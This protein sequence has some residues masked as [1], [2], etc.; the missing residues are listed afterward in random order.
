MKPQRDP[1]HVP[2]KRRFG[3]LNQVFEGDIERSFG[4][5]FKEFWDYW[6]QA[7]DHKVA[8]E[9]HIFRRGLVTAI[10]GAS[11]PLLVVVSGFLGRDVQSVWGGLLA[12]VSP[13][14]AVFLG[15]W[16]RRTLASVNRDEAYMEKRGPVLEGILKLYDRQPPGQIPSPREKREVDGKWDAAT[17]ELGPRGA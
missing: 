5:Y 17:L 6:S 2:F 8:R 12:A 1:P 9:R 7:P 15:S 11:S 4:T 13:V 16:D 14:G 3:S 10:V